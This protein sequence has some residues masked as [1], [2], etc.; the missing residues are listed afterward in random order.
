[1]NSLP[2]PVLNTNV[3]SHMHILRSYIC[4]PTHKYIQYKHRLRNHSGLVCRFG[5]NMGQFPEICSKIMGLMPGTVFS[6]N[7]KNTDI[8]FLVWTG[9]HI[10]THKNYILWRKKKCMRWK[11]AK[12]KKEGEVR[13][14]VWKS[15]Y[16]YHQNGTIKKQG[17]RREGRGNGVVMNVVPQLPSFRVFIFHFY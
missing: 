6:Q 4:P 3:A 16:L 10:H 1:M 14:F 12:E 5:V 17:R 2:N 11:E 15:P 7:P 13:R 9:T 8:L